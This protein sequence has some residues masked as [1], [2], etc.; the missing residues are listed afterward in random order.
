MTRRKR[1]GRLGTGLAGLLLCLLAGC[2]TPNGAAEAGSS[3][4]DTL[5]RLHTFYEVRSGDRLLGYLE[6][7][8]VEDPIQPVGQDREFYY[9]IRDTDL[10]RVGYM[11]DEGDTF[12]YLAHQGRERVSNSSTLENLKRFFGVEGRVE[13]RE[14][15]APSNSVSGDR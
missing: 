12:R 8:Y 9:Y 7:R 3:Q 1:F 14:A 2:A 15:R 10:T 11:T 13:L 5:D 6:K 4:E